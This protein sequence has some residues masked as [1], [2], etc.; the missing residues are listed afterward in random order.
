LSGENELMKK[1][2]IP[3][4]SHA[5]GTNEDANRFEDWGEEGRVVR[6]EA[7]QVLQAKINKDQL[8]KN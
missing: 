2:A 6:R 3:V 1:R 4:Q 8:S 5:E 7:P